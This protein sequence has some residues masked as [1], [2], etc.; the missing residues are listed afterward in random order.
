[1]YLP[2]DRR[3]RAAASARS[4]DVLPNGHRE[5]IMVVDDEKIV[6]DIAAATLEAYGYRVLTATSGAQAIS[7]FRASADEIDAVI[8][9][10]MMPGMD[11][12]ATMK[13][14]REIRPDTPLIASSGIRARAR[15]DPM[16]DQA[17]AFLPKPYSDAR[18]LGILSQVLNIAKTPSPVAISHTA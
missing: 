13:A 18:L 7:S 11:G 17:S 4:L 6:L 12:A 10:M 3:E 8:V 16:L 9:D 5:L 1:V 15:D 2:A 14:L